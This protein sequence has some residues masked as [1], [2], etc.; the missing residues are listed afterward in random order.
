MGAENS[1]Q[2]DKPR[3]VGEWVR[4]G[5]LVSIKT[6]KLDANAADE[7]GIYPFFTCAENTLR[8]NT[9]AYDCECVLVAGNGDLNV[10]YYNGKF[11]AYQRT[12]IIEV[13][14]RRVL[15]PF[16][17]YQFLK[18]YV[19]TLREQSIGGVIK[20]IK[21]CNLKDA[22]IPLPDVQI[23]QNIVGEFEKM[24]LVLE[25]QSDLS[26]HLDALVKSRFVE[27]FGAFDLSLQKS[28]WYPIKQLGQ[29]VSGATP[30]TSIGKYWDG[31]IKWITPA[32]LSDMS[33]WV[34][35]SARHITEEGL[36]SCG[37]RMMPVGT[38]ILSS[39]API[40]KM[41]LLGDSMCCNQGFK[42]IVCGD[43]VI[44]EYLYYLLGFNTAYLNSLGR[45]ATF[46]ELSKRSV[47]EIKI[48]VP[49]IKAQGEFVAF[50]QQ[51]DKLRFAIQE[52][53]EKLETL[54]ASLMQEYFG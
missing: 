22:L 23:Q 31:G 14:D 8:I 4:L 12:Y 2:T 24:D 15:D 51:V 13:L 1:N 42:N 29:V 19:Q 52:Q 37:A 35:D 21:L 50:T 33:G 34:Y 30:K 38:V 54:K 20:Y 36:N 48:P 16:Y 43:R 10:K 6:G 32:E 9:A 44:P 28:A 49:S 39:R 11:N 5:E 53:I 47:E 40:G 27:M 17:L 3:F 46:K 18:S 45:G 41:A 7:D 26:S 25:K